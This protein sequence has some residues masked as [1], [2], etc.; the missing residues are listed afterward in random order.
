MNAGI[1]RQALFS[2]FVS[3]MPTIVFS[4]LPT[5]LLVALTAAFIRGFRTSMS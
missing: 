2:C 5:A 4:T 1:H 3:D